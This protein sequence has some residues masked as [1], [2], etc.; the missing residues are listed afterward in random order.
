MFSWRTIMAR[1]SVDAGSLLKP[2]G[3]EVQSV[4]SG[5]AIGTSG[6]L[7]TLLREFYRGPQFELVTLSAFSL[8]GLVLVVIGV[9]SAVGY[10]VSLQTREIGIRMA[11]GAQHKGTRLV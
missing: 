5:V 4:D 8:V 1:T 10:I 3:K 11:L 6:T 7:E 2:M 9:F